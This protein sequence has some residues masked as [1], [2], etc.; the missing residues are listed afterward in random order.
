MKTILITGISRGIGLATA[1]LFLDKGWTVFGTSTTGKTPLTHP[2]LVTYQLDIADSTSLDKFKKDFGTNKIDV[3][4]NNA[5]F[6][7]D[8][9]PVP[10]I[11]LEILRKDMEVNLF[12][13]LRL[14]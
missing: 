10:P 7:A 3:L 1:R 9:S 11:D 14:T 5:G 8:E 2:L 12:G 4:V 13:T 6:A